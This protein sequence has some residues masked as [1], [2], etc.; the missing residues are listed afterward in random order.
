MPLKPASVDE[1]VKRVLGGERQFKIRLPDGSDLSGHERYPELQEYL[2]KQNLERT[3][4][5]FSGSQLVGVNAKGLYL[6]YV[7]GVE[8]NLYG[9]NLEEA[10]LWR[11]HLNEAY[12]RRANFNG[13]HLEEAHL[14]GVNLY[15]A[16]LYGAHLEKADFG[17]ADLRGV[18]GLSRAKGL[19]EAHFL[20]TVVGE[21]EELVI[22]RAQP[23]AKLSV[24][25][26]VVR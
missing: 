25:R 1:L 20:M 24:V 3:P 17:W 19:D 10:H 7:R 18:V 6:P 11:A 22:R 5:D 9:A 12:L 2:R 14:L 16:N 26:Y 4:L 21:A 8:T 15:E 13:A 23:G